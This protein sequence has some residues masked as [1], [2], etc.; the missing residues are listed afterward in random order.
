M[1]SQLVGVGISDRA[2]PGDD[3]VWEAVIAETDAAHLDRCPHHAH[4]HHAT[5]ARRAPHARQPLQKMLTVAGSIAVTTSVVLGGDVGVIV[6][7]CQASLS[8]AILAGTA[9]GLILAL[10][11]ARYQWDRLCKTPLGP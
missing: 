11:T 1:N 9:A 5:G 4:R 8:A 6:H 7:G 10:L 2:A 3:P